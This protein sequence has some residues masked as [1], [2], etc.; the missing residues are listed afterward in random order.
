[1]ILSDQLTTKKLLRQQTS[2]PHWLHLP[3]GVGWHLHHPFS[4]CTVS[5]LIFILY[6]HITGYWRL[7]NNKSSFCK[8]TRN[9]PVWCS[10]H[11]SACALLC[12]PLTFFFTV[13]CKLGVQ[14]DTS[15][16]SVPVLIISSQHVSLFEQR[17]YDCICSLLLLCSVSSTLLWL[18]RY[19]ITTNPLSQTQ[20]LYNGGKLVMNTN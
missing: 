16:F 18:C 13:I 14:T 9:S 11:T 17:Y 19:P 8:R 4:C 5:R 6:I 15:R 2:P 7:L 10:F 20:Q 1:M 12:W 3:P